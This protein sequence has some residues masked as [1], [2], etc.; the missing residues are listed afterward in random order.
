MNLY[1]CTFG[2]GSRMSQYVQ[3]IYATTEQEAEEK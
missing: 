3:P 1:Y 2:I